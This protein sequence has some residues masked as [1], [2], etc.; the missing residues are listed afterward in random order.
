[1]KLVLIMKAYFKTR[2]PLDKKV[3]ENF[4]FF[5]SNHDSLKKKSLPNFL[6]MKL[7]KKKICIMLKH[8]S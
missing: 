6:S 7:I 5:K 8:S 4:S 3:K 2:N 1:M